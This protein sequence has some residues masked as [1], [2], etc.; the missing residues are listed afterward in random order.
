MLLVEGPYFQH[1]PSFLL[2]GMPQ[3]VLKTSS[4]WQFG[5]TQDLWGKRRGVHTDPTVSHEEGTRK[6]FLA[7][8]PDG[9]FWA[10]MDE[11]APLP[12]CNCCSISSSGQEGSHGLSEDEERGAAG[13]GKGGEQ[14]DD[15]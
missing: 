1:P 11:L 14:G 5:G 7:P 3:S 12:S 15:S 4:E 8:Q 2:T 10:M 13:G 6:S 9:S